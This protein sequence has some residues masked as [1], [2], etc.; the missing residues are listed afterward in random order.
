M[1]ALLS[2][3]VNRLRFTSGESFVL[4]FLSRKIN[5]HVSHCDFENPVA[6]DPLSTCLNYLSESSRFRYTI[7]EREI[8]DGQKIYV[9]IMNRGFVQ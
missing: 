7:N 9:Y 2:A 4:F 3:K 8:R 5:E 1:K 6:A